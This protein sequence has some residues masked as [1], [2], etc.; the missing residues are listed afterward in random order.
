MSA[1]LLSG[2]AIVA[3]ALGATAARADDLSATLAPVAGYVEGHGAWESGWST[4]YDPYADGTGT[5][6]DT[7]MG[8]SARGAVL[9]GSNWGVQGDAWSAFEVNSSGMDG[10]VSGHL[11]WHSTDGGALFGVFGSLGQGGWES[12]QVGTGGIEAVL[13]SAHWRLYG[14]AGVAG[15][16]TGNA[17]A[18]GERDTYATVSAAYFFNPN[19]FVSANIG[20]DNWTESSGDA[21]PEMTWGAK[22]EFKPAQSPVSMYAAYEGYGFK[23]TYHDTPAYDKGVDNVFFV[24]LRVPLG[25]GTLQQLQR[26]VGLADLNP[27]YG[28]TI[29]R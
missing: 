29:N 20:A 7:Q 4:H 9:F 26:S 10:G 27:M 5:W 28:D 18:N 8:G 25:V 2:C 6:T 11:T 15:G 14:Q 24:G 3:M 19:F 17:S 16:L 12:G 23:S 13:N 1:K 21:S 22:I